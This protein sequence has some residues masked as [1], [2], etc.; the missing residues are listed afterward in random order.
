LCV[1]HPQKHIISSLSEHFYSLE[2]EYFSR[3]KAKQV[4]VG[5]EMGAKTDIPWK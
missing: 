5:L 3:G 1:P 4:D 2:D